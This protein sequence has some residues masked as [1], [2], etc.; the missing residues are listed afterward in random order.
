MIPV[1]I[2]VDLGTTV[3]DVPRRLFG[4]F[5]EHL[6]RCVYTGIF[7]PGHP[8]ADAAG[9]RGDVLELARE[10]GATV[11]RYPG[12]NFVSGYRWEDGVGPVDERPARLDAAWHSIETNR[13]GLHE[14]A[15]WARA[16][17]LELMQAVNLGTRGIAEA[18]DL[19]EYAN[20]PGGTE[21]SDRRRR[22]GAEA[23]FDIRL[24]CLGNEP[25]GPWQIGHRT[26][27]EYGR[28]AA[29]TARYLRMVDPRVEL[30]AAGSSGPDMPTFGEWERT[31]LRHTAGLVDHVSL[32]AYVEETDGD[33]A[34]FLGSGA[35]LDRYVEDV[36]AIIDEVGAEVAVEGTA[37]REVGIAVDEWNVWYLS[38]WNDAGKDAVVGGDWRQHPPLLED[39]YTATDAVVVG[40]LLISLLRHADRVRVA[41]QAQL[42]N[43]I[44]PIRTEP[45]GPAWRQATFHPFALTA[46]NARGRVMRTAVEAPRVPTPRHGPVAVVDAV[47]TADDAGGVSLFAVNRSTTDGVR[48]AV[49]LAAAGVAPLAVTSADTVT[50]PPG[51]DRLA[52]NTADHQP[53]VPRPLEG[54]Q[55]VP[56]RGGSRL[57]ATLPPVSW[58]VFR[59]APAAGP[60]EGSSDPRDG[61]RA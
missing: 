11:V 13:F 37:T 2:E 9:F 48:L 12:G 6:G 30:V 55:C 8:T 20:H 7:E 29:E 16:A 19:L 52:V 59:L 34:S 58:T 28:L 40:S 35:A 23:P 31:V 43:V 17:G 51:G 36:A 15:G 61:A 49:D 10:L 44:A 22:N 57:E 4:T 18:A 14:M 50:V 39:A 46:A 5:V 32:H 21:L 42:V 24:W 53:V 54:A 47:A 27:D 41:N 1:Q 26:A 56:V 3:A 60:T 38:R 45:G 25:D 33:A